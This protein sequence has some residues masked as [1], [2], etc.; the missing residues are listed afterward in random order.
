M[1][2]SLIFAIIVTIIGVL[3]DIYIY[4][5]IRRKGLSRHISGAYAISAVVTSV[6]ILMATAMPKRAGGDPSFLHT[7]WVLFAYISL[8][9][10]R[11]IYVIGSLIQRGL[12]AIWPHRRFRGIPIT[13]TAIGAAIFCLMWWGALINKYD[14]NVN[15]V[16]IPVDNLPKGFDGLTIAQISDLHLGTYGT[17]TAFVAQLVDTINALHPDVIV[18]TGDIVNRHSQ[19]ADPFIN[20]LSRLNA[21]MGVW[22]IMGNHDYGDYHSWHSPTEKQLDIAELQHAQQHM[23]WHML[24]NAHTWLRRG[25][26]SI[27]LIGVENIGDKPFPIY[28][29]LAKAYPDI[30]DSNVKILLSHNP[31]HWVDSIADKPHSNIHLTLSGHTHAMQMELFGLSPAAWRYKTWGGLYTDNKSQNL[32]VNIGIGEVGFP[33][34]IGANPEITLFTLKSK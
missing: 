32:Y 14:I 4:R 27:A 7:I 34:R 9:L 6:L 24:N 5:Q 31:A 10:P 25:N 1:R 11:Y 8:Y 28:G 21:R 15:Q 17:D 19:E 33:A 29:S 23:G 26:D 16:E 18:F 30:N 22:S 2:F 13:T 12:K 3:T 20:T